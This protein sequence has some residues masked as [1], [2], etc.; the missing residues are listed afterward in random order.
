MCPQCRKIGHWR[1]FGRFRCECGRQFS[2]TEE[3]VAQL[4]Q[5]HPQQAHHEAGE[6]APASEGSPAAAPVGGPAGSPAPA[7]PV[8]AVPASPTPALA[9]SALGTPQR[10]L[11]PPASPAPGRA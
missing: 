6:Q 7:A 1:S 11:P 10:P 2:L 5:L 8:P 3:M 4:A 9:D